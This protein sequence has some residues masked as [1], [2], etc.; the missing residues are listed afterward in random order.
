MTALC[1]SG[2]E[3]ENSLSSGS[4]RGEKRKT[5]DV[6]AVHLTL[7]T[8]NEARVRR[9][10]S[11]IFR[12][13]SSHY[14]KPSW[15]EGLRALLV[16]RGSSV[17]SEAAYRLGPAVESVASYLL[18]PKV[19]LPLR[20]RRL[21]FWRMIYYLRRRLDTGL[22][23]DGT[24]VGGRARQ[25]MRRALAYHQSVRPAATANTRKLEIIVGSDVRAFLTTRDAMGLACGCRP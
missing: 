25:Y 10:R 19:V 24:A 12:F 4:L 14:E 5:L 16:L 18:E 21:E 6:V 15:T 3:D 22:F 23:S 1:R 7:T 11:R 13:Y 9:Q 20:T 17:A 2:D 8:A